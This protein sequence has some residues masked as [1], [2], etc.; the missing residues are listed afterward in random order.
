MNKKEILFGI[1]VA[2]LLGGLISL[3]ASS[4]PD[5]LE[6]VAEDKEFLEKAEV[7]PLVA[8]PIPD[9]SW[10]G[11]KNEKIAASLAGVI[12]VLIMFVLGQTIGNLLKK[13]GR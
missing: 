12:G 4:W 7:Q 10:P 2:L 13:K 9:Y 8:S 3:F 5:G 11:L 1:I 6:R